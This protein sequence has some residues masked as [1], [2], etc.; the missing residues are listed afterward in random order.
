MYHTFYITYIPLSKYR[1]YTCYQGPCV[2]PARSLVSNIVIASLCQSLCPPGL[3]PFPWWR[4]STAPAPRT[5]HE[6]EREH[7]R[8]EWEAS[9]RNWTVSGCVPAAPRPRGAPAVMGRSWVSA[10]VRM[11]SCA[12]ERAEGWGASRCGPASAEWDWPGSLRR[13]CCWLALSN[14]VFWKKTA[15]VMTWHQKGCDFL[16]YNFKSHYFILINLI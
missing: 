16:F 14:A 1:I 3:D 2:I 4:D 12:A 10:A 8:G 6:R 9:Q 15:Q 13:S 7:E 11:M 5:C